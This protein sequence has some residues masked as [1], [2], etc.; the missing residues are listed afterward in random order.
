MFEPAPDDFRLEVR[1]LFTSDATLA[2]ALA[3]VGLVP[4][5]RIGTAE[6]WVVPVA[7]AREAVR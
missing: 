5:G 3:V 1:L 2:A 4:A 7:E 6:L